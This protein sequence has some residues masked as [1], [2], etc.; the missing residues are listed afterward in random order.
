MND[1][2]QDAIIRLR[3]ELNSL[4]ASQRFG[5]SNY[6]VVNQQ[7]RV[8][9]NLRVSQGW[10]IYYRAQSNFPLVNL[11]FE[12]KENGINRPNPKTLYTAGDSYCYYSVNLA[13]GLSLQTYNPP[14]M[15]TNDPSVFLA[16]LEKSSSGYQTEGE[17]IIKSKANCDGVLG[18]EEASYRV[19]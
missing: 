2:I 11:G 17:I 12:V 16:F 19:R 6:C 9:T 4:K 18:I 1:T 15:G 14:S 8:E 10:W 13:I 5:Q 3:T 7:C